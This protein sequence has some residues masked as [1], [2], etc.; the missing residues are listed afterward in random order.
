MPKP[1]SSELVTGESQEKDLSALGKK[2][3]DNADKN[4]RGKGPAGQ[5]PKD[6][7]ENST[8]AKG[9]VK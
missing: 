3:Y 7:D 6:W 1:Y 8:T 4:N 5:Y 9:S 2:C